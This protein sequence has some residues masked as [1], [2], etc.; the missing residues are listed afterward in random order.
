MSAERT[1]TSFPF[2]TIAR[3]SGVDYGAVLNA[4]E[5]LREWGVVSFDAPLALGLPEWV[6]N[7]IHL[8]LHGHQVPKGIGAPTVEGLTAEVKTLRARV[9]YLEGLLDDANDDAFERDLLR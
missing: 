7:D 8:A 4:A 6:C 3:A 5:I 2:M 9:E 1:F